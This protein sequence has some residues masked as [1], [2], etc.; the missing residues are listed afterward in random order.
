MN[1][2]DSESMSIILR[3][4]YFLSR[5]L[6]PMCMLHVALCLDIYMPLVCCRLRTQ[7]AAH[8][9]RQDLLH[10]L[11]AGRHPAQ[12]RHVPEHRRE[13]QHLRDV[14][15]QDD[16]E[17]SQSEGPRGVRDEPHHDLDEHV[18]PGATGRRRGL[19]VLGELDVH[20]LVLLLL[21]N[22]HD[23]RVRGLRRAPEEPRPAEPA[24]L[25]R[26]QSHLHPV[27]PDGRVGGDELARVAVL[28]HE[29]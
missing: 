7:Y 3:T 11:R 1:N 17:V 6:H 27:R 12:S 20:R 28:D 25:C 10:V 26:L 2:Y 21:H 29:H 23:D 24:A 22:A 14:R 9:G 15:P 16:E 5:Y 8:G 13:A 19:L 18:Q 4:C